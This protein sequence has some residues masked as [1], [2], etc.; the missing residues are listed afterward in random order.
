MG[1]Q[2]QNLK[3]DGSP[4]SSF[5]TNGYTITEGIGQAYGLCIQ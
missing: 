3:S 1:L 2:F 4:D 5:G